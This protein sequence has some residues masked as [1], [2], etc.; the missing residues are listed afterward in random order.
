VGLAE[1]Y[2]EDA[3]LT[4]PMFKTT[5]GRASIAS[6]FEVLFASFPDWQVNVSNVLVDGDQVAALT[7]ASAT[8][9]LGNFGLPATG[10]PFS[11]RCVL[12]YTI[13]DAQIV[14][15]ERIYDL[16]AVIDRL[17][18]VRVERELRAASD[19]QRMLFPRETQSG[20]YYDAAG[21]STPCRAIGGDFFD[22]FQI[23]A[24]G[25]GVALGDVSGKGPAAALLASLVQGMIAVEASRWQGPGEALSQLNDALIRRRIEPR[26][27][28]LSFVTVSQDGLLTYANAGHNPPILVT[29]QEIRRL[30]VGG[31]ML[32]VFASAMFQEETIDLR[33]GDL[34]VI[35]SDGVTEALDPAGEEFGDQRL[36]AFAR[37]NNRLRP[38]ALVAKAL[39]A[40]RDFS[41][42]SV[43]SDD[44]TIVALR[45]LPAPPEDLKK[46]TTARAI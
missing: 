17:E 13:R 9:R 4:S 28:T 14:A 35:F 12:L 22:F 45:Y 31:P 27:A 20:A 26:F 5:R 1:L 6:S 19:V 36:L 25:F 40:V 41:G 37:A 11:Y 2:S 39:D 8:D 21:D 46:S 34:I 30:D 33:T 44:A 42:G 29:E 16:T 7:V 38:A 15:E 18:K 10:E 3:V 24:C 43:H 32:G 23:P